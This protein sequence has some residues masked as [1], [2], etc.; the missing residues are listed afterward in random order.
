MGAWW[1]WAGVL[2]FGAL[3]GVV[4]FTVVRGSFGW[5]VGAG[6][7]VVVELVVRGLRCCIKKIRPKAEFFFLAG[8]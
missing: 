1:G 2:G 6:L 3:C 4:G 8:L 5:L 7:F